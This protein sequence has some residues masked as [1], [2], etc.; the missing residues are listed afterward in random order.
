MQLCVGAFFAQMVKCCRRSLTL[1][2]GV[3]C[4]E[5]GAAMINV[6]RAFHRRGKSMA[7]SSKLRDLGQPTDR[8]NSTEADQLDREPGSN[9]GTKGQMPTSRR[10][11]RTEAG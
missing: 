11:A 3:P 4:C 7:R 1:T 2:A 8:D 6:P 9:R 10:V 5:S